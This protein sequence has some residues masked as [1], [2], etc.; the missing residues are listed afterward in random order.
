MDVLDN[1]MQNLHTQPSYGLLRSLKMSQTHTPAHQ[2]Y[3]QLS[4]CSCK[5][6]KLKEAEDGLALLV[7]TSK[8]HVQSYL[9]NSHQLCV[10]PGPS[11]CPRPCPSPC[12]SEARGQLS[13]SLHPCQTCQSPTLGR[14]F[15]FDPDLPTGCS[16]LPSTLAS[17]SHSGQPGCSCSVQ[18]PPKA[19]PRRESATMCRVFGDILVV[20]YDPPSYQHRM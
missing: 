19:R 18:N 17:R 7:C 11:A 8:A 16:Q 4:D 3:S 6:K 10:L 9:S 5:S 20:Q 2:E 13:F 14:C 15:A 12:P 1:Q